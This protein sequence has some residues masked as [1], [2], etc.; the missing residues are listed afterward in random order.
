MD[1]DHGVSNLGE[2]FIGSLKIEGRLV[3]M[4]LP[5]YEADQHITSGILAEVPTGL[6]GLGGGPKIDIRVRNDLSSYKM[7]Y[8]IYENT[9]A[10]NFDDLAGLRTTLDVPTNTVIAAPSGNYYRINELGDRFVVDYVGAEIA[11]LVKGCIG[12]TI[13]ILAGTNGFTLKSTSRIRTTTGADVVVAAGDRVALM[14]VSGE[15]AV[16]IY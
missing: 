1:L 9:N 3:F 4:S 14:M 8:R 10:A 6:S 13:V 7:F 16:Q 5:G 12:L 2:I 11:G 15:N